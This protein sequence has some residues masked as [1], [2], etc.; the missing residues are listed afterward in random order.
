MNRP[1]AEA[2]LRQHQPGL[3]PSGW[4]RLSGIVHR[5]DGI[6]LIAYAGFGLTVTVRSAATSMHGR[7]CWVDVHRRDGQLTYRDLEQVML[8][9]YSH[10]L[11]KRAVRE[12][13]R[14]TVAGQLLGEG[15]SP[16][17]FMSDAGS[18]Q[19]VS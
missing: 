11:W 6:S 13:Y 5:E 10:S 18:A 8:K 4:A 14:K 15:D 3:L 19:S 7:I 17:T 9:L 12:M 16:F 1:A 2:H